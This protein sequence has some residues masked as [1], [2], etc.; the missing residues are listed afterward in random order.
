M[1]GVDNNLAHFVIGQWKHVRSSGD[2][3]VRLEGI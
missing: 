3:L 2:D 1:G